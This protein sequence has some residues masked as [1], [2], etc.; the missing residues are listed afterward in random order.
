MELYIIKTTEIFEKD[1]KRLSKKYRQIKKDLLPVCNRL[2]VG[3][4]IGNSISGSAN[5]LYKTRLAS[6]DQKKGKRGGFRLIYSVKNDFEDKEIILHT[7]Y[8]KS[9][10]IDISTDELKN[11]MKELEL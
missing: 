7:I 1:I 11:I 5:F 8:A 2:A 3:E 10:K 6:S 4:F 9:S